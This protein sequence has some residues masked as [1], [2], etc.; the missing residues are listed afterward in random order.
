MKDTQYFIVSG[1]IKTHSDSPSSQEEA[2]QHLVLLFFCTEVNVL[3][4]MR[5]LSPTRN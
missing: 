4:S 5:I 1:F 2:N 3:R